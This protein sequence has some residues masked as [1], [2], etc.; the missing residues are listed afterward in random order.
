LG[1]GS[2]IGEVPVLVDSLPLTQTTGLG[3]ATGKGNADGGLTCG[4][5]ATVASIVMIAATASSSVR[6]S[7][8]ARPAGSIPFTGSQCA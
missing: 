2:G 5:R 4:A 6:L 7:V 8:A 1:F 3:G